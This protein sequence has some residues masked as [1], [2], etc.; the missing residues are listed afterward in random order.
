MLDQPIP[1]IAPRHAEME[2]VSGMLPVLGD[3]GELD[4]GPCG[5]VAELVGV[6]VPDPV[7]GGLDL[8][9][10]L[11]L[12]SK[13]RSLELR[14][15]ITRA[16]V[17]PGVPLDLAAKERRSIGPLLP[18]HLSPLGVLTPVEH[19][20]AALAGADVLRLVEADGAEAPHRPQWPLAVGREQAVRRVL[21]HIHFVA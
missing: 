15:E 4:P 14:G 19:E 1:L 13:E 18:D 9:A 21:D 2:E 10:T 5:P 7:P 17:A 11:E 20:R 8:G 16:E 3:G 6:A 12:A